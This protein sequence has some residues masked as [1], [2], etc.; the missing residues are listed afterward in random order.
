MD[1]KARIV[2]PR[3]CAFPPVADAHPHGVIEN[4]GKLLRLN[5][6]PLRQPMFWAYVSGVGCGGFVRAM[7]AR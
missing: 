7:L 2:F 4:Q 5:G 1:G 6:V 3:R